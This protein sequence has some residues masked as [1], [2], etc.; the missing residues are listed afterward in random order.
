VLRASLLLQ[1][2]VHH[3]PF[4]WWPSVVK[5]SCLRSSHLLMI[6]LPDTTKTVRTHCVSS[7]SQL[8]R[9]I[10]KRIYKRVTF[11]KGLA[12]ILCNRIYM[13]CEV[14]GPNL[15]GL[16]LHVY[17]NLE[18]RPVGEIWCCFGSQALRLSTTK[19]I[20]SN[21]QSLLTHLLTVIWLYC[22]SWQPTELF[23]SSSSLPSADT[24][25]NAK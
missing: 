12:I 7:C 5:V 9:Y 6:F 2:T 22:S 14:E 23:P 11:F 21:F 15:L 24:L 17:D 25:C 18:N 8:S 20:V 1:Y 16:N 13:K 10:R 19:T 3:T 4:T